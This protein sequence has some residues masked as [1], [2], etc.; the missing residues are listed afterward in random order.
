MSVIGVS[1]S[2]KRPELFEEKHSIEALGE[3]IG[4]A[5]LI[6]DALPLTRLTRSVFDLGVLMKAKPTAVLVNIG[7]GE[8]VDEDSLK[9]WLKER[10]ESRYA[11]DVFWKR[12]GREVFDSDI[13]EFENFGGTMHTASAQDR[14]AIAYAQVAAAENVVRFLK[15]G[16]A[17]NK[18]DI[19]EYLPETGF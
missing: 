4:R 16:S 5:D 12:Q 2:F 15:T 19:A 10:L 9:T 13:W 3:V 14:E 11:T 18:V 6:V 17:H 7:R 1:R 8:T